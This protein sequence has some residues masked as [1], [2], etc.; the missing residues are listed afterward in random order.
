MIFF[1]V[2]LRI[3]S[4]TTISTARFLYTNRMKNSSRNFTSCRFRVLSAVF[5]FHQE[6]SM[7]KKYLFLFLVFIF[8]G[9][10]QIEGFFQ[11]EETST[12][13]LLY[14]NDEHG[15]IYENDG[16]YKGVALYEM[17]EE[18]EKNCINCSVIRLS[19]GDSYTGTAVSTFVK[20]ASMAEV[21]GL[22]GYRISALGNHEF[23]FGEKE[24]KN[25]AMT[26]K[27]QYLCSNLVSR[28]MKNLF[29]PG[30]VIYAGNEK[31]LFASAIT[32]D[33]KRISISRP[34]VESM[35]AKPKNT[36]LRALFKE[37]TDLN[38]IVAHES[39]N[40]AK[41]WVSEL[42]KKPLVVFT[43]HDHKEAL[44]EENGVLF[45]Q[46]AGYLPSYARVLI[47]K[48][49]ENSKVV[50]AEIVPLKRDILLKSEGSLE[51]KK[52]IDK[53]L[54]QLE[55]KAGQKI[56]SA[57]KPLETPALQKLFACSML[58]SFPGYDAAFSNP[59]GFRDTI[60]AGDI[61][62]SDILS[63][64]PFDNFIVKAT[65]QGEDL[66]FDIEKSGNAYCGATKKDEKWFVGG[67][68]IDKSKTYKIITTD[69][70]YQGGDGYRFTDSQGVTTNVSWRTP[71]ENYLIESSKKGLTLEEAC[72][73]LVKE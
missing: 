18:E 40:E 19:G 72:K 11:E 34:F 14:T 28:D 29:D 41:T 54:T 47:E 13:L 24:L 62:K 56:I 8:A 4:Y 26:A 63:V 3:F 15:H 7:L 66:I 17:W 36:V 53:Y 61:K 20:G 39:H 48:K 67:K 21:M 42:A 37:N 22:L 70:I 31:I 52:T 6:F 49:G 25:N 50:N 35:I 1:M 43:A 16:W 68:E 12:I 9:C 44:V 58:R 64:F 2:Y 65:V 69:F 30:T 10:A 33:V 71:L 51:V 60:K 45:I 57:E 27:I 46:N 32:E 59:G 55:K 23:D 38:I 73:N 5:G